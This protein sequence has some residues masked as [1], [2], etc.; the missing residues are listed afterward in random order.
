MIS[1]ILDMIFKQKPEPI[2]QQQEQQPVTVHLST[3]LQHVVHPA[4]QKQMMVDEMLSWVADCGP[5]YTRRTMY[6]FLNI[7]DGTSN[8]F[9]ALKNGEIVGFVIFRFTERRIVVERLA[10]N[11]VHRRCGVGRYLLGI[12]QTA[13]TPYRKS[14]ILR[15]PVKFLP[16]QC[17]LRSCGWK[18]ILEKDNR[19]I[20]ELKFRSNDNAL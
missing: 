5:E 13:L 11:P 16:A 19:I 10:V 6:A 7:A 8:L 17:F 15:V 4:W 20:F 18:A 9:Y 14:A 12:V 2:A 3:P 1:K